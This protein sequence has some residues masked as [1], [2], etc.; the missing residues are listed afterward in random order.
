MARKSSTEE[1]ITKARAIYG[2]RYD[3][4]KVKY[5]TNKGKVEVVCPIHGSFM[6]RASHHYDTKHPVG[7]SACTNLAS[8]LTTGE[9]IKKARKIH[10]DLYDYTNTTYTKSGIKVEVVC[11]KHGSFFIAPA[12][13][14]SSGQGCAK[15]AGIAKS[16]TEEFIA[17]AKDLYGD[18]YDYSLVRY[19]G[20]KNKVKIKCKLHGVF[21]TRPNDHLMGKGGCPEC[22]TSKK[23]SHAEWVAKAVM[24][25]DGYYSYGKTEYKDSLTKVTIT[26]PEHGDFTQTPSSHLA[27][28]GCAKCA[29]YGTDN[30]AIYIW[31]AVGLDKV[32]KVGVTSVRLEDNRICTVA[33]KAEL[34][35]EIIILAKV[36][37]AFRL[38]HQLLGKGR[39]YEW[40]TCFNG[41]TEFRE[42]TKEELNEAVSL[43]KNYID[44]KNKD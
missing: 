22:K 5:T 16:N 8:R 31:K 12:S 23:L 42:F 27:G 21:T 11:K 41:N 40:R 2:D 7:C 35:A 18:T 29:K 14:T 13:H 6:V 32:Y 44:T 4:G 9:F 37:D 33:A 19:K 10:G 34:Q 26:C 28:Q 30:D 15:C 36:K 17:K 20:N 3:Y 43:I 1:F 24:R 39:P 25:H 38:E